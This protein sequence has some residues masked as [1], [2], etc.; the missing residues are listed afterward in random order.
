MSS[1]EWGYSLGIS[2]FLALLLLPWYSDISLWIGVGLLLSCL[3]LL[4]TVAASRYMLPY[5]QLAILIGCIQLILAAW[6]N[7]Y[8]P[9]H[10]PLYDLGERLPE[11]L[12]YA[13]PACLLFAAGL[14]AGFITIKLMAHNHEA[15]L[16]TPVITRQLVQELN[17]I[18][19][20][21]LVA[22]LLQRV[23]PSS[24]KFLFVLLSNMAY[25]GA[26]GYVLLNVPGWKSRAGMVIGLLF[27]KSLQEGMFH[28]LIVWAASFVLVLAFSRRWNRKRIFSA[29]IGGFLVVMI[30]LAVKGEYRDQF[31]FGRTY[32]AESRVGAFSS[33]VANILLNPEILI[34]DEQLSRTFQRL[35][36][37]WIVNRAMLWTPVH[38]PYAEG[39][40]IINN[41]VGSLLPRFLNPRKGEVGGRKDYQRY[42]GLELVPG[43]SM[44]LGYAGEM[45]IN[46]GPR[47]GLLGMGFYGLLI[48]MGFHWFYMRA[49]RHPLWW[50]WASYFACIVIKAESSVGYMT[51]WVLK[52]AVVMIGVV[53]LCPN[54]KQVL[55]KTAWSKEHGIEHRRQEG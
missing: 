23:A 53:W 12:S 2:F 28:D 9:T 31:W 20:L 40:T 45:Y 29:I 4:N 44:A 7:H 1:R 51:N 42:T 13:V 32:I 46:F 22:T 52:A 48:G 38:E 34:S 33:L 50:A 37:G 21:G 49:L 26:F 55:G 19:V 24:L 3:V 54:M 39:R 15:V 41:V 11:Y 27:M 14:I 16:E 36:Q 30:I 10:H 17:A 35:N 43:T 18:F 5:P 25:V 47:W 8:Y 6:G